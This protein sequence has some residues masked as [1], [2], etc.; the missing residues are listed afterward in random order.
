M[1]NPL[2]DRI[3]EHKEIEIE[4][5]GNKLN[6]FEPRVT[7]KIPCKKQDIYSFGIFKILAMGYNKCVKKLNSCKCMNNSLIS[8]NIVM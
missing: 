2:K 7:S 3:I 6:S 5:T 1:E 4:E 8:E